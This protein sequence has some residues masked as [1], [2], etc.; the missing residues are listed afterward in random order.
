MLVT[1]DAKALQRDLGKEL[2]EIR[3]YATDVVNQRLFERKARKV[4]WG[5]KVAAKAIESML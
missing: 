2:S 4:P 5:V 1:T 3:R